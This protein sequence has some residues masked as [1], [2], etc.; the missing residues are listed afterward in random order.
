MR[1]S[2]I[3]ASLL[4]FFREFRRIKS[5]MV[6][7]F[8]LIFFIV[9]M[10]A[11][12]YIIPYSEAGSRWRDITYWEDC[13]EGVPPA[14][15]S[16]SLPPTQI[17]SNYKIAR[18]EIDDALLYEIV[19]SYDHQWD[20]SPQDLIF[21]CEAKYKEPLRLSLSLQRPDNCTVDIL[22]K[23]ILP[24]VKRVRIPISKEKEAK[25]AAFQFALEYDENIR[26]DTIETC[27]VLFAKACPSPHALQ[28]VYELTV[29]F[30]LSPDDRIENARIVLPGKVSGL[31]GADGQKR[32]I[33]SGI[34]T[35][36]K[37]ALLIGF[38]TAAVSIAIGVVYGVM[39][40]Y[41]G[42][43][44]DAFMQRIFEIFVSI[45]ILPL[46]IVMSAVF[47]PSVWTMII[48][49]CIFFWTI[50][51][52]TVRSMG[53]QIKE[54]AYIEAS[55]SIGASNARIIFK[56][57]VPLLIP[58]AFAHMALTVPRAIVYESTISLLGL[59]DAT[60]V[61]WGQIL[62]DGF[63]GGAMIK[64]LWWWIIPPGL[65]IAMVSMSFAFIGFAMDTIL[66]PKLRAR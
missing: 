31:L 23:E 60:I 41:L 34:V 37:W 56:H 21:E 54:E 35:G 38:L 19:F 42:G 43:W 11:E 57:M 51:V 4:D 65:A 58:Y 29:T 40:A 8:I 13:P 32:D 10:L 63:T 36:L 20:G 14:W 15:T 1:W 24:G 50:P 5:G 59:G 18:E 33:W 45:P 53:L 64:G 66:N 22:K 12:A 28:G 44:K 39:C 47:R 46:L 30:I 48:M 55:Q 49:M 26:S 6:G 9:L 3:K 17:I 25:S 61:T 2:D 62:H 27:E 52:K 7:L 16:R